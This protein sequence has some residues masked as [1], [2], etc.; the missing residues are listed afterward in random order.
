MHYRARAIGARLQIDSAP[1][2]GTIVKCRLRTETRLRRL[3]R[4]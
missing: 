4:K 3:P 2:Q 1:G